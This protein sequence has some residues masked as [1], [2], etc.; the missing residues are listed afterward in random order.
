MLNAY[1]RA[2][3]SRVSDCVSSST[4]HTILAPMPRSP[5][6][7]KVVQVN[8]KELKLRMKR[9]E[10]SG[11]IFKGVKKRGNLFT[12]YVTRKGVKKFIGSFK[13]EEQAALAIATTIDFGV[14]FEPSPKRRA[15][16]DPLWG[17]FDEEA[18]ELKSP[19][20]VASSAFSPKGIAS[21]NLRA[22]SRGA[23]PPFFD[24]KPP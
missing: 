2:A 15:P 17:I 12:S 4:L 11:S 20:S 22:S 13:E 14:E 8:G 19:E 3:S 23:Q 6:R 10:T 21:G 16:A 7:C 5:P 9:K 18:D 24:S 1:C